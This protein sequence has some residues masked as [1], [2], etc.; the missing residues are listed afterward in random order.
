MPLLQT[1]HP[2]HHDSGGDQQLG[3]GRGDSSI[4]VW[5]VAVTHVLSEGKGKRIPIQV[6]G[7][8]DDELCNRAEV[9]L[10]PV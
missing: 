10:D 9:A 3:L 7:V 4:A 2:K 8:V 5:S 6:V 1:L